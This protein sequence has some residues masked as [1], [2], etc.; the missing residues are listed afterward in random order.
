MSQSVPQ[1]LHRVFDQELT[2]LLD[3]VLAGDAVVDRATAE[4]LVRLL[5][6]LSRVQERHCVDNRAGVKCVWRRR[7]AG[8]VHG[9]D[10]RRAP[11]MR[12]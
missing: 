5:G 3:L 9:L 12:H 11:C 4:R 7:P 2:S 10:G 6:A 1:T 8:G